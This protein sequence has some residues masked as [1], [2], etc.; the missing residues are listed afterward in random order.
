M[1]R[2]LV[3]MLVA[4][5]LVGASCGGPGDGGA[6][7]PTTTAQGIGSEPSLDG[8][9]SSTTTPAPEAPNTSIPDGP[10]APDFTLALG[11]DR[12]ETFTLSQEAKPVYMVFWAEW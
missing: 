9:G 8:G 7:T 12:T 3:C 11:E 4:F 2:T 5:C 1:R 6:S 10:A